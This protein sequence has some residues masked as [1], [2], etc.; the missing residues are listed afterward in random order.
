MSSGPTTNS[1]PIAQ[2]P[3][4][5]ARMEGTNSVPVKRG[6]ED[7]IQFVS[8]KPVKKLRP[9]RDSPAAQTRQ[10]SGPANAIPPFPA[11]S[12]PVPPGDR[13]AGGNPGM[14]LG[15]SGP[16]PEPGLVNRRAS[17]PSM[18]NYVFPQPGMPSRSS[19]SSPMLSPKQLPPSSFP[20]PS[21]IPTTAPDF[22]NPMQQR[23]FV[24]QWQ[25]SGLPLQHITMHPEAATSPRM[26]LPRVQ[27][28]GAEPP[29]EAQPPSSRP[30][31]PKG[32]RSASDQ[33]GQPM[34]SHAEKP[35]Q[36]RPDTPH[37]TSEP[38]RNIQPFMAQAT[39]PPSQ[40]TSQLQPRPMTQP[41]FQT[42]QEVSGSNSYAVSAA[43]SMAP[44]APCL[45]CEQM[46][47]QVLLN[48]ANGFQGVQYPHV[49]H[50]WHGPGVPHPHPTHMPSPPMSSPGFAAGSNMHQN[51]QPRL[52]HVPHGHISANYAFTQVPG[53]MAMHRGL[54][55]ANMA[56][57]NGSFQGGPQTPPSHHNPMGGAAPIA[58]SASQVAQHQYV[59]N[60]F[61][62]PQPPATAPKPAPAAQPTPP[63]PR[64]PRMP[65][66]PPPQKR[67][68]NLIVDIAETCEELFPWDQV[69]ER[70]GVPRQ[71]VV[72]TFAA[73][74]QLPLLRCTTDKKRHGRLATNRLKDYTRSKNAIKTSSP[75]SAASSPA[76]QQQQPESANADDRPIL[77]GVMELANSM[78][79]LGLPSTLTNRFPGPW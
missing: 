5:D 47:Q 43:Q 30:A 28:P 25:V 71:K 7:D 52:Q 53:Q 54:P 1:Y 39:W 58:Q 65:T 22:S 17:L 10:S 19:R 3:S 31:T 74:I 6:P 27:K 13:P 72:E 2:I 70:H 59:Q 75:S 66:P 55:L 64:T 32:P 8:S 69:A 42:H 56:A 37:Q 51:Q 78:S 77:P 4:M 20:T 46:R 36:E 12:A 14:G 63:S 45:A 21:W 67:S 60:H 61:T 48:K 26:L 38:L 29:R 62:P 23:N 16:Q 40:S 79:P 15:V 44:K 18:E 76:S 50:G 57:G 9:S 34:E 41:Q 11:S 73:I 33:A 35:H 68:P 49:H 24:T